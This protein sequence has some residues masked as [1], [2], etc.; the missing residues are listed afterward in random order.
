MLIINNDKKEISYLNVKQVFQNAILST[1]PYINKLDYSKYIR[2]IINNQ[3][4]K[5]S[6]LYTNEK[7]PFFYKMIKFAQY[8]D[9][10]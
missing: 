6:N 4:L 1:Y 9:N 10:Y 2:Y 7:I 3:E 8:S 5:T